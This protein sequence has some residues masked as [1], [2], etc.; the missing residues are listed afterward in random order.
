MTL[1]EIKPVRH[2]AKFSA[3]ILTEFDRLLDKYGRDG[4]TLDPFAGVGRV[5]SIPGITAIGIELEPEWAEQHPRNQ[6]GN[7]L[8]LDFPDGH[9]KR[10]ITSPTYANRM[11][12][13]HD[14][15]ERCK[16]C[17]GE[18]EIP[19]DYNTTRSICPKCHGE[20]RRYYQRNTYR[21]T[22]NRPLHPDN[23]GAMPWGNKYREFHEAAWRE[24]LRALGPGHFILNISNHIRGGKIIPV[25]EWHRDT[26]VKLGLVHLETVEVPTRRN[27]QGANYKA[28][29]DH[30]DIHVFLREVP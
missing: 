25:S 13:C 12:D 17:G 9:F 21:H 10:V 11:A 7:A 30:E 27:R 5:H 24:A 14:A 1:S 28:R 26:L 20:G 19:A 18:G 2:P 8:A 16:E 4:L 29:V 22:L 15:Q 23:S 6:V 3:P